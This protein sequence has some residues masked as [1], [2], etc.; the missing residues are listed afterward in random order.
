MALANLTGLAQQRA[1]YQSTITRPGSY[2][3][4]DV[5]VQ[6]KY[7]YAVTTDAKLWVYDISQPKSPQIVGSAYAVNNWCGYS[8]ITVAGNSA[9]VSGNGLCQY[10][11]SDPVHPIGLSWTNQFNS[12]ANGVAVAN[13]LTYLADSL[14]GMRIYPN[15]NPLSTIG[16]TWHSNMLGGFTEGLTLAGQYAL[17]PSTYHVPIIDVG[18]PSSP[19]V[20]GQIPEF[21]HEI[22]VTGR[23]ALAATD[24]GL[25]TWDIQNPS[26]PAK[27]GTVVTP[28]RCQAIQIAGNLAYTGVTGIFTYDIS[29]PTQPKLINTQGTGYGLLLHLRV[30]GQYL[31]AG[32]GTVGIYLLTDVPA[33]RL[34]VQA[35]ATNTLA[36][37]WQS[38]ATNWVLDRATSLTSPAWDYVRGTPTRVGD[39]SQMI[40]SKTQSPAYFRLRW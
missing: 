16:Q 1:I 25:E 26:Q 5:A 28:D 2:D 17:L 7:L 22:A 8:F 37:S 14:E 20:V 24:G 29:D 6:G 32:K 19:Q 10:D 21:V 9:Y 13:G 34:Q 27:V 18:N 35:T 31:Y 4:N 36:I 30:F 38:I 33:P 15:D 11:L 3:I 40:V 39:Q 12:Q 23:Y